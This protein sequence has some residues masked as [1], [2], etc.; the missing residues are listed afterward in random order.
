MGRRCLSA[1]AQASA[2]LGAYLTPG[3]QRHPSPVDLEVLKGLHDRWKT[4]FSPSQVDH[5]M[6]IQGK[7]G[8][9]KHFSCDE[10]FGIYSLSSFPTSTACVS[11][12]FILGLAYTRKLVTLTPFLLSPSPTP[13]SGNLRV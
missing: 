4:T 8:E 5:L 2:A 1:E 3:P 12:M 13:A 9:R 7:I 10:L 11:S 6:Q